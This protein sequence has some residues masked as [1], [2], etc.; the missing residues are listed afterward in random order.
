MD[1]LNFPLFAAA[2]GALVPSCPFYCLTCLARSQ[3]QPLANDH[4]NLRTMRQQP[5]GNTGLLL[6][7]VQATEEKTDPEATVNQ[8][9]HNRSSCKFVKVCRRNGFS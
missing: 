6:L 4:I 2:G 1:S 8:N 9:L 5:E 3:R 7:A